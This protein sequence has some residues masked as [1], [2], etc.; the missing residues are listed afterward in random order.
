MTR[1][2]R[3]GRRTR[4]KT[5]AQNIMLKAFNIQ[6]GEIYAATSKEE[7]IE[8]FKKDTGNDVT[9]DE[10]ELLPSIF[11]WEDEN[12]PD[13]KTVGD[14]LAALVGNHARLIGADAF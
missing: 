1:P 11:P 8:A 14:V 9:S 3:V 13:H 5:A 6:E 4:P 2:E 10:V 12:H 7:A